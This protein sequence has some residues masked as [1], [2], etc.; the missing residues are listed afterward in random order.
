MSK[1]YIK[2]LET[3]KIELHFEK[4]E[5]LAL[6]TEQKKDLK[7]NYLWS[8]TAQA[9][10]SRS[11]HNQW[12]AIQTAKKLGFTEEEKVGERLSYEEQLERKAE[13]AEH[14][15]ERY[16]QYAENAEKRGK[17]LQSELNKFHGDIAFFTQPIIAGHSG[18]QSF[19][20]RRQRIFDRYNKGFEEYRK[21]AYFQEKAE[22][23][24]MT[25]DKTQLKNP[26]Y[27]NNRIEECKK[28]IRKLE[29]NLTYYE[30]ILNKKNNNEEIPSFY[31]DKTVEQIQNWLDDTIDKI[32]WQMDKLAYM[33][34]CMDQIKTTLEENGKKMYTKEDLKPGYLFKSRHKTWAK[35]I[36]VNPK[37]I[38]AV[39]IEDP[40]KGFNASC[41]YAEIKEV[42]IPE[43]WKDEKEQKTENPFKVGD[44]VCKYRPA[45][46]SIYKAFQ[47]I[48]ITEKSVVIQSIKIE[49]NK[50][51]LNSF[52]S[53]KQERKQVKKDRGGNFV[54]NHD[55]W[56]LYR[57][58]A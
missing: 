30:D 1:N 24:R 40:L 43:D 53:D 7:S 8:K 37:T 35:V 25:A 21:S 18:S 33:Q 19:A 31:K 22:T 10:V 17:N 54:L 36:R 2:N 5:Y 55:G 4:S 57:Y 14:R 45:D 48:K 6:T 44:I 47:V 11:I 51:I 58:T 3:G 49:E 42:K 56:Y 50:P 9:W 12:G 32:E 23:A 13:K 27:L 15:A 34:N 46:N 29:K 38:T 16:D 26:I 41:P 39:Y 52:I 28:N 20:K